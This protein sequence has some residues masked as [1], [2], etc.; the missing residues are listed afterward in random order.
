MCTMELLHGLPV[1]GGEQC[2]LQKRMISGSVV[3]GWV[4]LDFRVVRRP[5]LDARTEDLEAT[6]SPG[7]PGLVGAEGSS[8]QT[9]ADEC[10]FVA[11]RIN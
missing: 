3:L 4:R 11:V 6:D 8:E 1:N 2:A 5:H 9:I 7:R 10:V